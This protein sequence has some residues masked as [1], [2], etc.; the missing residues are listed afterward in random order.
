MI[1]IMKAYSPNQV[2]SLTDGRAR[3]LTLMG[4]ITIINSLIASL[5]VH[6]MMVLPFLS[7]KFIHRLYTQFTEF[8]WNGKQA[9]IKINVLQTS[10]NTRRSWA[11]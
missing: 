5:Y 2:S 9:K 4:K 10:K 8:I 11:G 6:Q 1:L 7:T 3:D